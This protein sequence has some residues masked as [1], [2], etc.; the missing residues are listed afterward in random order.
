MDDNWQYA[1]FRKL[2]HIKMHGG[3]PKIPSTSGTSTRFFVVAQGLDLFITGTAIHAQLFIERCF[4]CLRWGRLCII[5]WSCLRDSPPKNKRDVRE[6]WGPI[7]SAKTC[8]RRAKTHKRAN[9]ISGTNRYPG[10]TCTIFW[11]HF[12][13]TKDQHDSHWGYS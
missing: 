6:F 9:S 12:S 13:W 1:Y 5:A 11:C 7:R 8:K 10:F 2:P 3:S 4:T